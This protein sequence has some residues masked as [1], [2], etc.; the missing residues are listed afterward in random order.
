MFTFSANQADPILP[1]LMA[2]EAPLSSPEGKVNPLHQKFL[3][4]VRLEQTEALRMPLPN[5]NS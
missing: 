3:S 2:T 5:L 1:L 4:D